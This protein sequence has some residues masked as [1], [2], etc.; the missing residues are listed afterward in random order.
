MVRYALIY[1]AN[2]ARIYVSRTQALEQA[3]FSRL[4]VGFLGTL[5][6]Q[7]GIFI[8]NYKGTFM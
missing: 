4:E 5:F 1:A 7:F 2:F 6:P 8:L 3:V